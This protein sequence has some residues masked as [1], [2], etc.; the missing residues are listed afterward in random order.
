M[1]IFDELIQNT[2]RNQGNIL[3][4]RD[5]TLWMID[6]TRAFRLGN[7]LINPDHLARCERALLEQLR[8]LTRE[9]VT[10]AVKRSLDLY[11]IRALLARRDRI[12]AHFDE[13]IASRGDAEVLFDLT[14]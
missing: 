7:A 3:W 9:S 2:D 14:P 6:H 10:Q 11:E 5:W 8:G 4:T 1:R 13:R 12:V